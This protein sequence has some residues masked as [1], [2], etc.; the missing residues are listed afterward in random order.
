MEK[1]KDYQ[2]IYFRVIRETSK[3]NKYMKWHLLCYRSDKTTTLSSE[4]TKTRQQ[5]YDIAKQSRPL[6]VGDRLQITI[7]QELP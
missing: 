1:Q 4:Y 6:A 7:Y 5:A 2:T 3:Y